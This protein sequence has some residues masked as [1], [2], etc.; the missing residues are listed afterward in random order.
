MTMKTKSG[1]GWM[2]NAKVS[3]LQI[4][5]LE[6]FQGHIEELIQHDQG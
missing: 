4:H 5:P 6:G 1:K 3:L 2:I